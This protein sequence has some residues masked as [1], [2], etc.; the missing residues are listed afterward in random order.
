VID[1]NISSSPSMYEQ[2]LTLLTP[3]S[4]IFQIHDL[5]G[6]YSNYTHLVEARKPDLSPFLFVI[7]RYAVFGSYDRSE[8][9]IREYKTY[10]FLRK[11]GFPAPEPL[12][13]D[14][15][16]ELLGSPGIVTSY[17]SGELIQL[18]HEIKNKAKALAIILAKI[19]RLPCDRSVNN[20]LLDANEEATWFLRSDKTPA[21]MK[22]HP[23]GE[24]VWQKA[25]ETYHHLSPVKGTIV[26]LDYW[27][28]N[29]LWEN[30]EIVAVIDW[31]ETAYGDPA[32]DVAYCR[33]NLILGGLC[34]TADE[35][36]QEYEV[37]MGKRTA[38][39]DFWGLAAAARPMFDPKSWEIDSPSKNKFFEKFIFDTMA[40]L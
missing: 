30:Q 8:K 18:P 17:V 4:V 9:A 22:N 40:G 29:I 20:F 31:E 39:L 19:H 12:Y 5:P 6:S 32:I 21:F 2:L 15:K 33:M 3:G 38:N 28:G 25:K 13:L 35:F 14:I 16:G 36:I 24:A 27:P 1:K 10:E 11:N 26:H 23:L 34:D 7:R 37:A